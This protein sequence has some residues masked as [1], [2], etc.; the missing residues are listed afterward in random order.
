[1]TT[2][3]CKCHPNSPFHWRDDPRP[4]I[5]YKDVSYRG[6][7]DGRTLSQLSSELVEQSRM[8]G[9]MVGFIKG[10]SAKREEEILRMRNFK[11]FTLAVVSNAKQPQR[12]EVPAVRSVVKHSG[13]QTRP[14]SK[15]NVPKEGVR[16]SA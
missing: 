4:S 11:T 7:K 5:F 13:D 6:T 8:D 2:K 3:R 9:K 12:D 16:K 1:M 10:I 15:Q 14:G